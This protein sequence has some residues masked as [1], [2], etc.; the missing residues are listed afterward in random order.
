[1]LKRAW[2]AL[3]SFTRNVHKAVHFTVIWYNKTI[4]WSM[5]LCQGGIFPLC[6]A[7][8]RNGPILGFVWKQWVENKAWVGVRGGVERG[9]GLALTLLGNGEALG[10]GVPPTRVSTRPPPRSTPPLTPTVEIGVACPQKTYHMLDS[11]I[12]NVVIN[13]IIRTEHVSKESVVEKISEYKASTVRTGGIDEHGPIT[14]QENATR[15]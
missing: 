7:D 5:G 3:L 8:F 2:F 10:T 13:T 4:T 9:G 14:I 12:H 15:Q 6:D 1:V 11:H